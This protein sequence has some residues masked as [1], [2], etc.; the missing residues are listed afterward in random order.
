MLDKQNAG[1]EFIM[2][3]RSEYKRLH[4]AEERLTLLRILTEEAGKR[5]LDD[6]AL[7]FEG[8]QYYVQMKYEAA[9]K[10]FQQALAENDKLA[11]SWNGLGNVY[12]D[13]KDYEKAK[14]AYFKAIELDDKF[15]HPWTGIGLV[16]WDQKDYENVA[17]GPTLEGRY[18]IIVFEIKPSTI[19]RVIIGWDMNN[20]EKAYWRKHKSK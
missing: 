2:R 3:Y 13:Q 16:Y 11:Y 7:S 10:M 18:L 6:L 5:D 17:M 9:I 19:A 15:A 20:N 4:S 14:E 8:S 12:R 1:R